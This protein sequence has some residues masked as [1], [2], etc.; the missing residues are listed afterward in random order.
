MKVKEKAESFCANYGVMLT[1]RRKN[2]NSSRTVGAALRG[3]PR[4]KRCSP[5]PRPS[6]S[7]SCS[8]RGRPRRA[9]PTVLLNFIWGDDDA[10]VGFQD[11]RIQHLGALQRD[12]CPVEFI[13]RRLYKQN[14]LPWR[15][16][17]RV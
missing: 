9:A 8:N 10:L 11:H 1:P 14:V 6:F 3:R 7:E 12:L 5:N 4:F 16:R 15:C 17:H 2:I 13:A